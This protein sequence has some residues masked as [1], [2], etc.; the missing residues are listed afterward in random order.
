MFSIVL[1]VL[2]A[3]ASA[4]APSSMAA[5][6]PKFVSGTQPPDFPTEA[7]ALGHFGTVVARATVGVDGTLKGIRI[8]ESSKSPLLD[9]LVMA[10]LPTWRLEPAKDSSGNPIELS[11][12]FPF[13]FEGDGQNSWLVRYTCD[14]FTRDTT[15]WRSVNPGKDDK[16][17]RLYHLIL[18]A[19]IISDKRGFMAAQELTARQA[20]EWGAAVKTCAANPKALLV[21]QF[22]IARQLRAL[23]NIKG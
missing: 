15:W 12:T 17:L 9:A 20:S 8:E 7:R 5:V 18:G 6:K 10:A 4:P 11:A 1:A 16:E 22:S 3:Q 21:D 19:R 14:Q 23:A 2:A 13:T